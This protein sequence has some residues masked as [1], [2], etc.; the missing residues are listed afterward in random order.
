VDLKALVKEHKGA[1][2]GGVGVIGL[3]GLLILL[4]GKKSGTAG[5][6]ATVDPNQYLTP[7]SLVASPTGSILT[8]GSGQG[9]LTP[10]GSAPAPGGAGASGVAASPVSTPKVTQASLLGFTNP[11]T[12]VTLVG[13][14]LIDTG[15]G[16]VAYYGPG[17]QPGSATAFAGSSSYVDPTGKEVYYNPTGYGYADTTR[18]PDLPPVQAVAMA[19]SH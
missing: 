6:G 9:L 2:I 12:P 11:N 15:T 19:Q 4:K 18:A 16:R 8:L 1:V 7:D 13:G 10:P 14:K 17:G 5:T 3:G